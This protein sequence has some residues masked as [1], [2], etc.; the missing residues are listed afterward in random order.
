MIIVRKLLT[1]FLVTLF[2]GALA[3]F[4]AHL[5]HGKSIECWRQIIPDYRHGATRIDMPHPT[6]SEERHARCMQVQPDGFTHELIRWSD[7]FKGFFYA[8]IQD[9]PLD[10]DLSQTAKTYQNSQYGYTFDYPPTVILKASIGNA[11]EAE[12]APSSENVLASTNRQSAGDSLFS[13]HALQIPFTA[14]DIKAQFGA[15]DPEKVQLIPTAVAGRDGYM[16][17]PP[18]DAKDLSTFYLVK[19]PSGHVLEI[20]VTDDPEATALYT[21]FRILK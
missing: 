4:G 10:T 17:A 7:S 8:P 14:T 11:A 1:I 12:I 2:I 21:S 6:E 13:V 9:P 16:I 3:Y 15:S 20:V 18:E 19:S 5:V